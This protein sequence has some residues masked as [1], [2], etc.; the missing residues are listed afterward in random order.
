MVF[1]GEILK[2]NNF[3]MIE[4]T[5]DIVL[6]RTLSWIHKNTLKTMREDPEIIQEIF[7]DWHCPRGSVRNKL[8]DIR[9]TRQIEV[10][11]SS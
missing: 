10:S 11:F 5:K 3:K 7:K 4:S 1:G 6:T 9:L 8:V 2:M